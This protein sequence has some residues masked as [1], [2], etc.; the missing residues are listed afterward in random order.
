MLIGSSLTEIK[1][2]FYMFFLMK[3]YSK[4]QKGFIGNLNL[5]LANSVFIENKAKTNQF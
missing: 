3:Q 4:G 2:V 5:L 1:M